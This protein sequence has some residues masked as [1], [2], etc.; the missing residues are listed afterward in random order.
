MIQPIGDADRVSG[1]HSA[2]CGPVCNY[3][4]IDSLSDCDRFARLVAVYVRAADE[5]GSR[6]KEESFETFIGRTVMEGSLSGRQ[7]FLL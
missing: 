7:T 5:F 3:H 6:R 1:A 2:R 4:W